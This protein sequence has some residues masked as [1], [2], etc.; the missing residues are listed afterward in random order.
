VKKRIAITGL[1]VM[2]PI[3]IDKDSYWKSLFKGKV[4]YKPITLFDTSNLRIH[5]AGEITDFNPKEILGKRGLVDL[6]R[7][8][9][10]LLSAL[11]FALED[12]GIESDNINLPVTGISAGTTF[13][14]VNSLSEFDRDSLEVGP[15]FVNPSRFPNTVI[16]SPASR[17]AIRYRIKGPNA[18]ISTGYCAALD[19]IDYAMNCIEFNRARRMIAAS[20]EEMCIQ[21]F[22]GFYQL[23][24]LSGLN[25]GNAPIS[26]PFDKSRDGIIFSEGASVLILEDL[27]TALERGVNIYGEILG[28]GSNFDPF[29][30]HKF[31]P[32]GAGIIESMRLALKNADLKPDDIDCIF[33]NANST[34]DADVIETQAIKEVFKEKAYDIPITAVKSMLGE[35]FSA[36]GGLTAIA[37]IGS[38]LNSLIPPTVNLRENDPKCDLNYVKNTAKNTKVNNVMINS[39]GPPGTNT[40]LIIGKY[41]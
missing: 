36:S 16:N 3:G 26:C 38:M 13:G 22:L 23:G 30:L 32:K 11:K 24:Y 12:S 21:T 14:S 28:I 27:D 19:A 31:N 18:T 6:D 40:V 35:A 39:F 2:S 20:V 37:A 29:R 1:G 10:L 8:T 7:S 33:A 17:A 4:G 41:K 9:T 15:N 5:A 34:K 25:G